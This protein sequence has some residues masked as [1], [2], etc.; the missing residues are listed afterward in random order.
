MMVR[1]HFGKDIAQKVGDIS[2]FKL[3]YLPS[4]LLIDPLIEFFRRL[5]GMDR[6]FPDSFIKSYKEKFKKRFSDLDA[7][8]VGSENYWLSVFHVNNN[9]VAHQRVLYTWLHLYGYA[10]NACAAFYLS[11]I[12][13]I[14]H[15]YFN[16]G[17]LTT[18]SRF[19][20]GVLWSFS[21]IL[22]L[23]YWI[24]YSHYYSKAVIRAFYEQITD[25]KTLNQRLNADR[26]IRRRYFRP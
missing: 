26:R 9:S 12:L 13:L 20:I 17:A 10:R 15:I 11:G 7:D 3:F 8:E 23:R 22:G 21:I 18:L 1:A 24:L 2:I 25:P 4:K 14:G 16:G 6:R 5:L 19:H